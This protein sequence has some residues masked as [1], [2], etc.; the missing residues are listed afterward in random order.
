MDYREKLGWYY[1]YSYQGLSFSSVYSLFLVPLEN[2]TRVNQ[3]TNLSLIQ[4]H[5]LL[6]C[7]VRWY[8]IGLVFYGAAGT[9]M[10]H[11]ATP[12][13]AE[14]RRTKTERTKVSTLVTVWRPG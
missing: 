11:F 10:A 7:L 3:M 13:T 6:C 2:L 12:P 1:L 4:F 8:G 5:G 9:G 14:A